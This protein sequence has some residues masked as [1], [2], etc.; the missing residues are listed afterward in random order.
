GLSADAAM[1]LGEQNVAAE[2][3]PLHTAIH[4]LPPNG[5]GY[6]NGNFYNSSRLL[7]HDDSKELSKSMN[8]HLVVAVPANDVVVYDAIAL[9]AISTLVNAVGMKSVRPLSG[10]LFKWVPGGWE[11]VRR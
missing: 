5:V 1:S 7:L 8:G 2:L 9:D 6:I 11:I 10:T 3:G 4:D